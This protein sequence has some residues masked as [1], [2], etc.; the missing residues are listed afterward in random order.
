VFGTATV[1]NGTDSILPSAYGEYVGV[2]LLA[3]REKLHGAD[4]VALGAGL[5]GK[6]GA[7]RNPT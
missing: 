1:Q 6:T 4:S 3:V 7:E 2:D 5:D